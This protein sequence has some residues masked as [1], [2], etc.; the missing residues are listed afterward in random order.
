MKISENIAVFYVA[1]QNKCIS[2]GS[3]HYYKA[4]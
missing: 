3:E 1:L 4:E 2:H